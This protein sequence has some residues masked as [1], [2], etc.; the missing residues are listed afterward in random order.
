[1]KPRRSPTWP[2]A[3]ACSR[4]ATGCATVSAGVVKMPGSVGFSAMVWRLE[5]Q[6]S[7]AL[8]TYLKQQNAYCDVMTPGKLRAH[9]GAGDRRS[10]EQA[11][12]HA[13]LGQ[14]VGR[15]RRQRRKRP[16][17]A[18][19]SAGRIHHAART[20]LGIACALARGLDLW[21]H[22]QS[23]AARIPERRAGRRSDACSHDHHRIGAWRGRGRCAARAS[24]LPRGVLAKL[25]ACRRSPPQ[26]YRSAI[27]G[28]SST[29]RSA[30]RSSSSSPFR[31]SS[32]LPRRSSKAT[33]P[34][35][36]AL[37]SPSSPSSD[38]ASPSV[39]GFG[40]LDWARPRARGSLGGWRYLAVLL[41]PLDLALSVARRVR[42]P[43]PYRHLAHDAA[44][45][46]VVGRRQ[47]CR[48]DARHGHR[49]LAMPP[50]S[51]LA[52]SMSWPISRRCNRC[53]MR[54]PRSLRPISISSRW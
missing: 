27:C 31:W 1:M 28:A 53:V 46:P 51:G 2:C 23:G 8:C 33:G 50:S 41:R 54:P 37:P 17:S 38:L 49:P 42:Q 21:L 25:R 16:A 26:S 13:G 22:P 9:L 4:R 47:P 14:G 5:Q 36:C 48:V 35:S 19:N 6:T 3:A 32:C 24:G 7:T 39:P 44:H 29:S 43:R 20:G 52:L 30:L 40:T 12:D 18:R 10:Q 45:R 34:G 15:A 11:D